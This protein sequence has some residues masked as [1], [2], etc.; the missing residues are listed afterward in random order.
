MKSDRVE[1]Q[2][3]RL[4]E[5]LERTYKRV[6]FYNKKFKSAGLKPE[7]IRS[8]RDLE[9]IPFTTKEDLMAN[10]PYGMLA[11]P[12]EEVHRI[13]TTTGTRGKPTL[14]FFSKRDINN[15][16][17]LMAR[18]LA[19]AEV[20]RGDS[21]FAFSSF[22]L[23]TGGFAWTYGAERIGAT[24]IPAGPGNTKMK[25]RM[26]LDLQPTVLI[27]TPS[28]SLYIAEVARREG[29]DLK[30]DL[31][32]RTS[33]H[34]AEPWSESKRKRIEMIYGTKAFDEYGLTELC[35][36]G[37]A[38]EC[39]AH[40]G[41]HVFTDHF[42]VEVIDP[43]T[44]EVTSPGEEGELVFTT[45][46]REAMPLLRYRTGDV[47]AC[48]DAEACECGI[49]F[50]RIM[51]VEGRID[52]AVF[53]KAVKVYPTQIEEVLMQTPET[54]GRYKIVIDQIDYKDHMEVQVE[55]KTKGE[56]FPSLK[57]ALEEE[58]HTALGLHVSVKLLTRGHFAF[59]EDATPK[60]VRVEDRRIKR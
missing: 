12:R 21:I 22:G 58:I 56:K 41:L 14:S 29:I 9:K 38:M 49:V 5:T 32:L 19:M 35:G 26:M 16:S 52:D 48:L 15:W 18:K 47:S 20:E 17:L 39:T 10:Y 40:E 7:D 43:T 45:L 4:K 55:M 2:E 51:R 54:T 11:I 44:G 13:H 8:L 36:P 6:S 23:S 42:L 33:I 25:L 1:L 3:S 30:E 34:G 24:L 37:V 50:P 57:E 60:L 53:V 31:N 59:K 28:Y 27:C 46:T